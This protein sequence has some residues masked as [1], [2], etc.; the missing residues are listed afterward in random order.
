[1]PS[2]T[3]W[4][5]CNVGAQNP[6]DYGDYFAWGETKNKTSYTWDNYKY[7]NK[8][9]YK[10][11]KYCY[12]KQNGHGGYTD[13]LSALE[14]KD[15]AAAAKNK[16]WRTPTVAEFDELKECCHWEWTQEHGVNGYVVTSKE[17]SNR[18]FLP[19]SGNKYGDK[20]TTFNIGRIGIYWLSSLSSDTKKEP[21][22]AQGIYLEN[23]KYDRYLWRRYLG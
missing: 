11:T 21:Y 3:L 22:W 14:V 1:M 16:N 17:N 12:D 23:N 10:L 18:I 8:D 15:D 6:W 5:T 9:A 4:A 2:G 13:T 19:A 7:A 20:D